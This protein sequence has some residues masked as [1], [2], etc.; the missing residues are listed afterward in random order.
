MSLD[1]VTQL[2]ASWHESRVPTLYSSIWHIH[3]KLSQSITFYSQQYITVLGFY[4]GFSSLS[5]LSFSLFRF[6]ID[7]RSYIWVFPFL[8]SWFLV[9]SLTIFQTK[10]YCNKTRKNWT[11]SETHK[12]KCFYLLQDQHTFHVE[13]PYLRITFLQ[14][15]IQFKRK[16]MSQDYTAI[17]DSTKR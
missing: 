11:C 1:I 5:S 16:S 10:Q 9:T 4:E 13:F 15:L 12:L 14:K 6:P 3:I 7:S 17:I 2:S 8:V